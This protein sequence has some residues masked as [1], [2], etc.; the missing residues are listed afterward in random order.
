MGPSLD[1][2]PI[3]LLARQRKHSLMKSSLNR[4]QGLLTRLLL[5]RAL[6]S[7]INFLT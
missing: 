2:E 7:S 5:F 3:V 1:I 6:L 4:S